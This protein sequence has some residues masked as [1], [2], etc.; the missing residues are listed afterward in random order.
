MNI[1]WLQ[2]V[3]PY[4]I[5][6]IGQHCFRQW[7]VTWQHQAIPW[8]NV[9]SSPAG[10]NGRLFADIFRCIFVNEKFYNFI[11]ISLKF[12]PKSPI[13]NNSA[14]VWIMAWRRIGDKWLSESMLTNI[15]AA[16]GGDELTHWGRD[17]MAAI[18]QWI[19][20]NENVWISINISLKFVPR[21]PIDNI[22]TLV[23]VMAWR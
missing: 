1:K 10:Q 20:L 3:T 11:K 23:Q 2:P 19:F 13:D 22:P 5:G 16:P 18:F 9:N 4:D 8:T 15:Y 6:N 7:L 14:S 12:V 21:G 17:K